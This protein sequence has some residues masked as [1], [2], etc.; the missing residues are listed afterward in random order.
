M[1]VSSVEWRLDGTRIGNIQYTPPYSIN[2]NSAAVPNGTHA[3]SAYVLDAS[4]NSTTSSVTIIVN[5]AVSSPD[6]IVPPPQSIV[7][8]ALRWATTNTLFTNTLEE[9]SLASIES[10]LLTDIGSPGANTNEED[11]I[12]VMDRGAV[13]DGVT[14]D[15]VAI[16]TALDEGEAQGRGVLFPFG[17]T[18][19]VKATKTDFFW[20]GSRIGECAVGL[21]LGDN[22]LVKIGGTI[23]LDYGDKYKNP[24]IFSYYVNITL[25]ENKNA[26]KILQGYD[27]HSPYN[28]DYYYP[29]G[30]SEYV[31]MFRGYPHTNGVSSTTIYL[32][33]SPDLS[34]FQLGENARYIPDNLTPQTPLPLRVELRGYTSFG[35]LSST[36]IANV[37]SV[38]NSAKTI[39]IDRAVTLYPKTKDSAPD[40]W[41][42]F[43]SNYYNK[44]IKI[45]GS[46]II[47]LRAITGSESWSYYALAFKFAR[48]DGLSI[49]GI[50]IKGNVFSLLYI[51]FSQHI[52]LSNLKANDSIPLYNYDDSCFQIDACRRIIVIKNT[53]IGCDSSTWDD[54]IDAYEHKNGFTEGIYFWASKDI[55]C[56]F[57]IM[58]Q[59]YLQ[60][61]VAQNNMSMESNEQIFYLIPNETPDIYSL[62]GMD[63]VNSASIVNF[64]QLFYGNIVSNS[65]SGIN[66]IGETWTGNK[67]LGAI[68]ANNIITSGL[69]NPGIT[70]SSTK[71]AIITDNTIVGCGWSERQ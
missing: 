44:N 18:F 12:N 58:N 4:G 50:T 66:I 59:F 43:E 20:Y 26:Y 27:H 56:V 69:S 41:Y 10:E 3:I 61:I 22:A 63:G 46:G 60:P 65:N 31:A 40:G 62:W 1:S 34:I 11:F 24:S 71:N 17:F 6:P 33:G 37:I 16:Q 13:G 35:N 54:T 55:I 29:Y 39:E 48:V 14:D 32:T 8:V 36:I 7:S 38:D 21:W 45:F 67:T 30:V 57:N 15:T 68:L 9:H 47:D 70:L 51:G 19:L 53:L 42:F 52:I 5:N 23:K 2:F 64:P 28:Y 49:D 25:F